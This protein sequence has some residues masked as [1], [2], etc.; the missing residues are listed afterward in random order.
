MIDAHKFAYSPSRVNVNQGD[1]VILR[2]RPQDA[3]HGLYVDG[4]DL[5]THANPAVPGVP[6]E[7]G[8]LK[9]VADTPGKFRFRCSITCGNLHPF[10]IGELNVES[11]T[12]GTNAPFVA[13]AAAA[14][15]VGAGG[16]AYV[17]RSRRPSD[18]SVG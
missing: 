10:M 4:Y 15:L 5:E 18:G 12:P 9:F 16:V 1:T 3:S 13:A 7:G 2:L 17:W 8:I 6:S 11:G 14:V